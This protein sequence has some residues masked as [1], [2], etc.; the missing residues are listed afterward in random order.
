MH[1]DLDQ[2]QLIYNQKT[3]DYDYNNFITKD[4]EHKE[5]IIDILEGPVW[6]EVYFSKKY[7]SPERIS[8]KKI[9][10]FLETIGLKSEV[11][12][13]MPL[14]ANKNPIPPVT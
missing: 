7:E 10:E 1:L 6:K 4:P 3:G 2:L 12:Y 5:N 8:N 13:Q 9:L 14:H 11:Y